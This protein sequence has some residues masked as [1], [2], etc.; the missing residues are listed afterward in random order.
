MTLTTLDGK[1][2][3]IAH[4]YIQAYGS[5]YTVIVLKGGLKLHVRESVDNIKEAVEQERAK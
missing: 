4:T 3:S 5:P 2:V 1:E